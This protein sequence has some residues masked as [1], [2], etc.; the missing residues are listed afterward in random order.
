M[1]KLCIELLHY[2]TDAI[3]N[4]LGDDEIN[5]RIENVASRD[6]ITNEEYCK[7]YEY[8]MLAYKC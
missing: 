2:I 3:D 7:I 6:D 4:D 5:A 8:A 1:K